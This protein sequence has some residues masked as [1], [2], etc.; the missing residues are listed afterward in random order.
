MTPNEDQRKIVLAPHHLRLFALLVDY[1]IA[2]LSLNLAQQLLM[3]E[4]WDLRPVDST[5]GG[6][7]GDWMGGLLVLMVVRDIFG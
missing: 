7:F 5:G 3:G 6:R 1:L 4:G 2:V